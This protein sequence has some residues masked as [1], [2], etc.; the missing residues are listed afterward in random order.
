MEV[1][2]CVIW[3]KN[4][5]VRPSIERATSRTRAY[6]PAYTTFTRSSTLNLSRRSSQIVHIAVTSNATYS[7]EVRIYVALGPTTS[8][9]ALSARFLFAHASACVWSVVQAGFCFADPSVHLLRPVVSWSF[10]AA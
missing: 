4:R 6:P 7:Y 1:V 8:A 2:A 5:V 10:I 9:P 3:P